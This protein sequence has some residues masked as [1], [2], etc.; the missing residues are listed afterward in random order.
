MLGSA[1]APSA[2]RPEAFLSA[3]VLGVDMYVRD[4]KN[5]DEVW[6]LDSL[7]ELGLDDGSFRSRDY[8]IAI[9]EES[10]EKAGFGRI[11]NRAATSQSV[12]DQHRRPAR[13]RNR[14]SAH[15]SSNGWSSTRPTRGS[16]PSTHLTTPRILA[17]FGFER[18]SRAPPRRAPGAARTGQGTPAGRGATPGGR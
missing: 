16:T 12:S 11:R 10:H 14:A 4:A 5:R 2:A 8:V 3:G 15:T 18:S 7:D 9:D 1:T 17:Q 6:L 13:R